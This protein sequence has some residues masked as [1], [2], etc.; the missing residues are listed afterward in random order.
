MLSLRDAG[1]ALVSGQI[2]NTEYSN[3][4]SIFEE[5]FKENGAFEASYI[6]EVFHDMRWKKKA[7]DATLSHRLASGFD[8]NCTITSQ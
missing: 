3:I 2:P 6:Y 4:R 1:T 8:Y 5:R 7:L